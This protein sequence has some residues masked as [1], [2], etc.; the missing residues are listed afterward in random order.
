MAG[1]RL[2]RMI[3]AWCC[4]TSTRPRVSAHSTKC[5]CCTDWF[6]YSTHT[7][8]SAMRTC[9]ILS[10]SSRRE[11]PE[12]EREAPRGGRRQRRHGLEKRH[13]RARVVRLH[14]VGAL[15]ELSSLERL[16]E[17]QVW[18]SA[19]KRPPLQR[20]RAARWFRGFRGV[21]EGGFRY[22]CAECSLR[23]ADTA[24]RWL[25]FASRWI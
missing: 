17:G 11:A 23:A 14:L 20:T 9:S 2:A 12:R 4:T 15:H 21:R 18:R 22:H 3:P 25:A 8:V 1:R 19:R 6:I 5:G 24:T 16:E 10:K 7:P 13:S